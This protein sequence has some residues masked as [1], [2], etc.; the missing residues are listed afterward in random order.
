MPASLYYYPATGRA[1]VIR[2]ALSAA[3]I[4]F[5]DVY[6]KSGFPPSEEDKVNLR[7]KC[8]NSASL[9]CGLENEI[10]VSGSV[11]VNHV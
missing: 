8:T 2:L 4:A 3:N 7:V 11:F 1:N 10:K 6:P 9:L 5:N